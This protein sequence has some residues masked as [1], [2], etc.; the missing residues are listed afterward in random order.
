[1]SKINQPGTT[2]LPQLVN[3]HT[4]A[5]ILGVTSRAIDSM[6]KR[7]QIPVI[8]INSKVLL[9]DVSKVLA[10]LNRLEIKPCS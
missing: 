5:L 7:R 9:F 6:A 8:K 3:K 2:I 1:M 4:L 10:A